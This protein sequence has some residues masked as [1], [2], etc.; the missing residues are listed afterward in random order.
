MTGLSL[1]VRAS[2][3]PAVGRR[4]PS[5]VLRQVVVISCAQR[6][7]V[8]SWYPP[9]ELTLLPKHTECSASHLAQTQRSSPPTQF[10]SVPSTHAEFVICDYA[11]DTGFRFSATFLGELA[12]FQLIL[13][14]TPVC[15][16][17]SVKIVLVARICIV[18]LPLWLFVRDCET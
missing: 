3:V 2:N 6:S 7:I 16:Q 15:L 4:C 13:I 1:P 8:P 10:E 14:L 9:G 5:D 12:A 17:S 18:S 11:I